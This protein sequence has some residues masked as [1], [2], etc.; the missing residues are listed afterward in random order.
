MDPDPDVEVEPLVLR[1]ELGERPADREACSDRTFRVVLVRLRRPEQGQDRIAAELLEGPA[2]P[3]E[4]GPHARVVRSDERLDVLGIELLGARGRTDEVDED[5]GDHLALLA[6]L[7]GW[8][9]IGQRVP[10]TEAKA[11]LFRILGP[12]YAANPHVSSVRRKQ[13]RF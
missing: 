5:R 1:V 7:R 10:A 12:A 8:R 6:R 13:V 11:R 3:L 2:V 4:L 9:R